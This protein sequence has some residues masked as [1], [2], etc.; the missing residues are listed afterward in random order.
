ML[1]PLRYT[2]GTD[3][4]NAA[5][6]QGRLTLNITCGLQSRAAN[7]RVNTVSEIYYVYYN[8]SIILQYSASVNVF[9]EM[10][11]M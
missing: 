9:L 5:Y 6:I 3:T 4:V 7:N 8:I 2:V 10:K 1:K 11:V